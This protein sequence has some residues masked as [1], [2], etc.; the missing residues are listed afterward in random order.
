LRRTIKVSVIG[1]L[2]L[3]LT[4]GVVLAAVRIGD[5]GNN[6]LVGTSGDDEGQDVLLGFAGT[7]DLQGRSAA[8]YLGGGSGPDVLRAGNGN[9]T[10]DGGTGEDTLSTGKGFDV[11]YAEDGDVDTINCNYEGGYYIVNWDEGLD[12]DI[13]ENDDDMCP[14][15]FDPSATTMTAASASEEGSTTE[16]AYEPK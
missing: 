5:S 13:D 4:A 8:D 14:G 2:L 16:G 10:L 12:T 11:V 3:A 15:V 9:D 1:A 7:D 6:D